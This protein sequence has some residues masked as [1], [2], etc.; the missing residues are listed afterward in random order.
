M[1]AL[2][3]E[4]WVKGFTGALEGGAEVSQTQSIE[5]S[6]T[7]PNKMNLPGIEDEEEMIKKR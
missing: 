1:R 4:Q 5:I 7:N 2:P 3:D 6:H